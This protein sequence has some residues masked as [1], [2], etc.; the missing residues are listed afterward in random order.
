MPPLDREGVKTAAL[1]AV[2]FGAGTAFVTVRILAVMWGDCDIGINAGAN[3]FGLL[4]Y[5]PVFAGIAGAA[6]GLTFAGVDAWASKTF[7]F[8]ATSAVALL[9]LWALLAWHHNPYGSDSY[10]P[11][12]PCKNGV[13]AWWPDAIP[14]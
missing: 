12:T 8:L 1:I 13:P 2:T 6:C 7:A 3:L 11:E 14:L 9:V 5:L 4:L 10:I